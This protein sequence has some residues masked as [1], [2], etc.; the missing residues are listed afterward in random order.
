MA[1][2]DLN[3][4]RES[5][6][7][8]YDELRTK[9]LVEFNE[10]RLKASEYSVVLAQNLNTAMQLAFKIPLEDYQ[11]CL[12]QAQIDETQRKTAF[13]DDQALSTLMQIQMNGWSEAFKSGMLQGVPDIISS[14]ELSVLY[15]SAKSRVENGDWKTDCG[16]RNVTLENANNC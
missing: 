1:S 13:Y 9:T 12:T 10:G 5:F 15:D 3:R 8:I 16:I 4:I 2:V 7:V 11:I 14:D 6:R